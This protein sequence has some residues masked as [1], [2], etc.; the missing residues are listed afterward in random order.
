[1]KNL[2]LFDETRIEILRRLIGCRATGGCDLRECLKMKKPV[3]SHHLGML[4][5]KGIIEEYKEGRDKYYRIKPEKRALV[6]V[7]IKIVG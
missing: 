4:R 3:I 6:R 1:M 5:D 2:W 7:I